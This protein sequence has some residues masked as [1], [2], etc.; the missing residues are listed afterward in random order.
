MRSKLEQEESMSDAD[1]G[2]LLTKKMRE[3]GIPVGRPNLDF[4]RPDYSIYYAGSPEVEDCPI[5]IEKKQKQTFFG[6]D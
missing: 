4:S 3:N 1:F 6:V 5:R 2:I